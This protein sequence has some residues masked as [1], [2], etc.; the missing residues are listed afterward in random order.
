MVSFSS[1]LIHLWGSELNRVLK[2]GEFSLQQVDLELQEKMF[3]VWCSGSRLNLYWRA[4]VPWQVSLGIRLLHL[5]PKELKENRSLA[6][7]IILLRY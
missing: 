4:A 7:Q 2:T 3:S 1:A 5:V 6:K